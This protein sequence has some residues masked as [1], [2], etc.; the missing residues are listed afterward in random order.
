VGRSLGVLSLPYLPDPGGTPGT[1]V[2]PE[3]KTLTSREREIL[4]EVAAGLS[5][6]EI[7]ARLVLAEATVKTHVGWMLGQLYLRDRVQAV[8]YA[9]EHGL[10]RPRTR[11]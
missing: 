11:P 4:T 1:S 3:V 6:A 10:V 7:A 8:V 2:P 5:N 9:Y